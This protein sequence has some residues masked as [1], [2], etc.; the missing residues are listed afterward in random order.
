MA[1]TARKLD[2][3]RIAVAML[4]QNNAARNIVVGNAAHADVTGT[5]SGDALA[6]TFTAQAVAS[7]DASD[8]A[9]SITLL[10]EIKSVY[11]LHIADTYA[12]KTAAT[13]ISTADA[14]DL[15]TAEALA[16]AI[17]A[18]FNTHLGSTAQHYTADSNTSS[19]SAATNLSSTETLATD[20]KAKLNAHILNGP[21]YYPAMVRVVD[22]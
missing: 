22:A 19:A 18:A 15:T 5:Q 6:P 14:S 10:N 8:L 2:A 16:N 17:K 12:H 20:L 3:P 11:N 1:Y 4:A 13:A 21:P 7:A 9:T